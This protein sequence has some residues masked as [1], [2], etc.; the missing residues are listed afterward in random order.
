MAG[1][2]DIKSYDDLD[3]EAMLDCIEEK[4]RIISVSRRDIESLKR[5][6]VT[7]KDQL[8]YSKGKRK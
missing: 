7:L 5:E 2:D 4:D 1:F 3:R 8:N 6:I